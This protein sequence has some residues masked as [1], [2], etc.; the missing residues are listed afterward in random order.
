MKRMLIIAAAVSALAGAAMAQDAYTASQ[1]AAPS[2]YPP[3][4]KA[5]QDRCTQGGHMGGHKMAGH[6]KGH[7]HMAKAAKDADSSGTA[8]APEGKKGKTSKDGE[9]G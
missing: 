3:C 9:R 5:G 1:G 7:H 4:T 2:D 6:M 8:G